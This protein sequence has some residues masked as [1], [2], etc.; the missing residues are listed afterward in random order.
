MTATAPEPTA[1]MPEGQILDVAYV[2]FLLGHGG[3]AIQMLA[4]AEGMARLDARVGIVVPSND[5]TVTL[6]QRCETVG[7]TCL[8]SDLISVDSAGSR[9]RFRSVLRLLSGIRA[10]VL[11]F[12]TGN[13][14][15]PRSVTLALE[16]IRHPAA[17]VTLQS[18][19]ETIVPG[20][21]RARLWA[22]GARRRLR[23]VVSPSNHGTSFQI[24]CGVPARL[25]LTIPNSVDLRRISRGDG[26]RARASLGVTPDEPIVLFSSRIDGQKRPIDALRIFAGVAAEFPA[27]QL[28]FVGQGKQEDAVR[29]EA[30][31]LGLEQRVRFPGYQTNVEDWL[32]AA[33]VWLLPTEREN[34]SLAVL[35]A[36]AAGCPVLSTRCQGNDEV[37]RDGE[38]ALTFGVGDV[39]AAVRALRRLMVE[40]SLREALSRRARVAAE[41]YSADRML[42]SY[43]L[44]YEDLQR[45]APRG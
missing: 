11:H 24:R 16:F 10:R 17:L 40:T 2:G 22:I 12:H 4:L 45:R 37:L 25:A 8:T 28:V 44:V 26:S 39:A 9:Q 18:P 38:N 31:F 5:Y 35:E 21:L 33:T 6:K 41:G 14:C 15:L 43:R 1:T 30:R 32:A 19:Y 13:S 34:F 42:E 20:S 23:A 7:L 29:T 27:A 36:L 3:D